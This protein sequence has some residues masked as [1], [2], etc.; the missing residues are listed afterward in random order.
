MRSAESMKLALNPLMVT[1]NSYIKINA[2]RYVLPYN[3]K[4][5][6]ILFEK[7]PLS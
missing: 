7:T 6:T 2:C 5:P 3:L 1:Y 4:G